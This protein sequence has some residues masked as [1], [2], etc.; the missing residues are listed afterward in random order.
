MK[1]FLMKFTFKLSL[2]IIFTFGISCTLVIGYAIAGGNIS[3]ESA[4]FFIMTLVFMFTPMIRVIIIEKLF[5]RAGFG[6]FTLSNS[7]GTAGGG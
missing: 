1:N 3:P 5:L 7:D 2:Y 4:E 6:M